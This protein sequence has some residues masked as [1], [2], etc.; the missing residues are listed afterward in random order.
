MTPGASDSLSASTASV[1]S[2]RATTRAIARLPIAAGSPCAPAAARAAGLVA[3]SGLAASCSR[4]G[5]VSP[6]RCARASPRRV[7]R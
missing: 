7:T 1:A 4:I 6:T 3:A 2:M 5:R